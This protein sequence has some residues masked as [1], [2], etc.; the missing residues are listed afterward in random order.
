MT[1][2][3]IFKQRR[4]PLEQAA[5]FLDMRPETLRA[6]LRQKSVPFGFAVQCDGGRWSYYISGRALVNYSQVGAA[7]QVI[8]VEKE[9]ESA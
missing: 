5:A 6:A 8:V 7:T 1:E 3:E 4:V 9:G 2:Q